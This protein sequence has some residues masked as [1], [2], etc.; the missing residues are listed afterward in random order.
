MRLHFERVEASLALVM[1]TTGAILQLPLTRRLH[2]T[3]TP[4]ALW[5]ELVK[6]SFNLTGTR[7]RHIWAR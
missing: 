7:M 6:A 2:G 3:T 1:H 5:I 4:A